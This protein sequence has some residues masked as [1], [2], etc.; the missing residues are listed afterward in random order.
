VVTGLM[1]GRAR[2]VRSRHRRGL[3]AGFARVVGPVEVVTAA[4]SLRFGMPKPGSGARSLLVSVRARS[5]E[6]WYRAQTLKSGEKCES[7]WPPSGHPECH[8]ARGAGDPAGNA[9]QPAAD[10]SGGG[11]DRVGQADQGGPPQEVVRQG[12]DH[13]PGGVG[14]ELAGGEVRQCLVFE[15]T[16]REFHDGVLAV[17]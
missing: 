12:G 14:E 9:Q 10:G 3:R 15:V 17:L 1:A 8:G 2:V 11:D 16:D 5:G 7:P 4:R 13:C 6:C